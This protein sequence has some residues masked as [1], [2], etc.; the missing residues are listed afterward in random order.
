MNNSKSNIYI[1]ILIIALGLMSFGLYRL[2]VYVG[3][4]SNRVIEIN[5]KLQTLEENKKKI[6][7]YKKILLKGSKEQEQIDSYILQ[8]DS[9]FKAITDLE[10]EGK[11]TG[12][13][14]KGGILSVS[15]RDNDE[16]K[17]FNAG[18]VIVVIGVEGLTESVD[19]YM[20]ALINLPYVSHIE[21]VE[22]QFL[23]GGSKTKAN[24][25]LIITEL[26]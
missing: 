1:V 15:K 2:H 22:V 8:G 12:L 10:K 7:L 5:T 20:S 23:E 11:K 19:T 25:T 9:V 13:F 3:N 18:E 14:E 4:F 16:L 24:I 26:I 6:E 17:D 21:K